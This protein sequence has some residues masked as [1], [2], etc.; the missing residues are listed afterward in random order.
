MMYARDP[1]LIPA[2]NSRGLAEGCLVILADKPATTLCKLRSH[3]SKLYLV[4]C[5]RISTKVMFSS[6][7][8]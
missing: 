3:T 2:N 6:A 8:F 1:F 4:F 7:T 5:P